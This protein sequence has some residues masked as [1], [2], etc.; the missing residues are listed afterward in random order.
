M[1][2]GKANINIKS[3]TVADANKA[4]SGS[5]TGDVTATKPTVVD[6]TLDEEYIDN[7]SVTVALVTNYSLYR[8]AN[9][10]SLPKRNYFIG[11]S[12]VSSRTLSSNKSEVEDYFPAIVGVASNHPDFLIRVKQYL[13]N[14]H[15]SVDELGRKFNTSFRYN[16]KR[17]Y[18][19]FKE[20]EDAIESRFNLVD[21]GNLKEL[22]KALELK[23]RDLNVLEGK[24]HKFGYPINVEDYIKYRHCLLY[25]HVAKDMAIINSDPNIRFYIKDDAK[26]AE[27]VNKRRLE[28]INAKRNFI[29]VI[30]N[31]DKFEAVYV[32]YCVYNA[33][34]IKESLMKDSAE[35][36]MEL[37]TFS[38]NEPIKFNKI[39]N[40]KD[41]LN[42][43]FIE[44]LI[45]RGELVRSSDNQNISTATGDFI[46][47]NMKEA[48]IWLKNPNNA[49]IVEAYKNKLKY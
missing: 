48:L 39:C 38:T 49:N 26:E 15:I 37:D 24:K 11:S 7:R 19:K 12:V 9:D 23:I 22:K 16:T 32:Q 2:Q 14:I 21:R 42:K 28:I 1:E 35:R 36:E 13:A 43:A 3:N 44:K 17:D 8:R 27:L 20:E 18:L 5:S 4:M 46:G 6:A 25:S 40:D 33:L 10:K 34:P 31:S 45:S 41:I 29:E 47:A 30:D